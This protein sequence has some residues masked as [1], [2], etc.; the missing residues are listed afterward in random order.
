MCV[1]WAFPAY[2]LI[3]VSPSF[4]LILLGYGGYPHD[5]GLSLAACSAILRNRNRMGGR[6]NGSMVHEETLSLERGA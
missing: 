3:P 5:E 4:S 6:N 2:F 1:S